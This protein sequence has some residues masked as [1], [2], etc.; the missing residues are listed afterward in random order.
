MFARS[1]IIVLLA[2]F[3]AAVIALDCPAGS[4]PGSG[5]CKLC[6]A[7]TWSFANSTACTKC[8]AGTFNGFIGAQGPD[9]CRR[10]DAGTFGRPGASRCR[11]CPAGKVSESFSPRCF[12]CGPGK[13]LRFRNCAPCS[14][15]SYSTGNANL[16]CTSCPPR[17]TTRRSGADS[18]AKCIPSPTPACVAPR[19]KRCGDC[20][21]GSFFNVE[22]LQCDVCP[23]GSFA[24]KRG[25]KECTPCAV[26]K[27]SP[28]SF[29]SN[30]RRCQA[31]TSSD[32][33]GARV[34]KING[35]PCP[36]NHFE[37][38]GGRCMSCDP[39]FR[40]D[41]STK[42]CVACAEG[43]WSRGG[44]VTSCFTCPAGKTLVERLQDCLCNLGTFEMPDGSCKRCPPGTK[45]DSLQAGPLCERCFPGSVAPTS[46]SVDCT[47]CPLDQFQPK[48][49][50]TRCLPCPPGTIQKLFS[51]ESIC[52]STRTNCPPGFK[53]IQLAGSFFRCTE[54]VCPR[55][56]FRQTDSNGERICRGCFPGQ[57]F[58]PGARE[59]E[60]CVECGP[61]EISKGGKQTR[62]TRCAKGFF[63]YNPEGNNCRCL[64]S[65]YGLQ[66][67][68]CKKC[69]PGTFSVY[70]KSVCTPCPP[71]T[72]AREAG[73]I[74]ACQ[75]CP[76]NT[77]ADEEGMAVCKNCAAGSVSYGLR[78]ASCVPV[79]TPWESHE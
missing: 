66:G 71:G 76:K 52:V 59:I 63:R 54:E 55:G 35:A 41:T 72:F 53:R 37:D 61:Q 56:T 10:C 34:C 3:I 24:R 1:P 27:F 23:P 22:T 48:E 33:I 25:A 58:V 30:C 73:T 32:T 47:V 39:G 68:I 4:F 8:E 18:L 43:A 20:D 40:L 77:F 13:E 14:K 17:T 19:F 7:G 26:G 2:C 78:E 62:C 44:I 11:P 74:I 15:G 21:R 60:R 67:G 49:G 64:E 9:L 12:A 75:R 45:R 31:G 28:F 5:E 6:P 46:G 36:S 57:R 70:Y 69:P 16:D 38:S 50:Q 42:T 29:S 79:T 65:G 51:R